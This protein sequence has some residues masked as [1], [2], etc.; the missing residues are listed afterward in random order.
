MCD[1]W[2]TT[3]FS[4]FLFEMD[5]YA[6]LHKTW[7]IENNETFIVIPTSKFYCQAH[8]LEKEFFIFPIQIILGISEWVRWDV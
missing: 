2:L 6:N 8:F 7:A 3:F 1:M 4:P 5:Q